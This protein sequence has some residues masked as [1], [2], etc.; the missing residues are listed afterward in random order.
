MTQTISNTLS[1]E[2]SKQ[3]DAFVERILASAGGA[4]DIFTM[5][6]GQKLGYYQALSAGVSLTSLDLAQQTNTQE[7]YAREWLEQQTVSGVLNVLNPQDGPQERRFSLSPAHA[8]VLTDVDSPNYVLPLAPMIAGAV[9]PIDQLI[10]AFKSGSGVPYK[11]YGEDFREG[12]GAINRVTFLQDLPNEWIPAIP[13]VHARLQDSQT[14]ARVADI[15]MGAGW[16]SIGIA[17]HFPGVQVD[18]FDNDAPSVELARRNAR[19]SGLNGQVNFHVR[20]AGDPDL[21][22]RYDLVLALECVHDM[23]DPVGA[24]RKMRQLAGEDG[25]VIVAD[26]RVSDEFTAQGNDVEWMMYGWSVLH[27]LPVGLADEHSAG[28]GTVMRTDTLR[29]YAQEA[30]FHEV[31]VLPIDNFFFRIYRLHQ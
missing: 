20:D 23:S 4:F 12:Q 30:G 29:R 25:A 26:E 17:Q 27:C 6:I 8:E 14:P 2:E 31:E 16:S 3:R 7:R 19:L 28:T 24:L 18:G 10:S 13:D 5:H 11:E 22:G 1:Q 21:A 15:G 9:R